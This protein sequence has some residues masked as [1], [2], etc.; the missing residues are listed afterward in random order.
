MGALV[1]FAGEIPK[2]G[3]MGLVRADVRGS[4]DPC[5]ESLVGSPRRQTR[6]PG[7]LGRLTATVSRGA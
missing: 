4:A 5:P 1:R 3:Q 2:G 7:S 6:G